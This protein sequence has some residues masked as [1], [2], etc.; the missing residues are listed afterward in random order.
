METKSPAV[1][2]Y[3][4]DFLTGTMLMNYEQ[5]GR[6]ITLLCLQHQQGRLNK[7]DFESISNNDEKITSKFKV[8]R[9]KKYYNERMEFE[10]EKRNKFV[11]SR[12]ANASKAKGKPKKHMVKHMDSHMENENDN[13][14]INSKYGLYNRVILTNKQYEKLIKDFDK[15]LIDNQIILLDEYVQSNDNKYKYK[16]FN[17]VLRKSIKE[18]WFKDK[19]YQPIQSNDPEWID[20][21]IQNEEATQEEQAHMKAM[22]SEFK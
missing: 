10:T 19:P 18:K 13:E 15:E 16:D 21:D 14:N 6:Y 12:H 17:L 1:L 11:D 8:D 2:L 3:T 4:S 20:K 5:K 9:D 22:L 7:Q